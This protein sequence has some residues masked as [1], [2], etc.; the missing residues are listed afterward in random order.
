MKIL[1]LMPEDL[2][3]PNELGRYEIKPASFKEPELVSRF[4]MTIFIDKVAGLVRILSS[5]NFSIPFKFWT[6]GLDVF[7]REILP[8]I[9]LNEVPK[10]FLK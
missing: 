9:V 5:R 6:C 7:N 1:I 8:Y 10:I 4:D 2:V 3:E